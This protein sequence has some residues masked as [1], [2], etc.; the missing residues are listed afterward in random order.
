MRTARCGNSNHRMTYQ[1]T[2]PITALSGY[3]IYIN[4]EIP[5]GSLIVD[6]YI[7]GLVINISNESLYINNKYINYIK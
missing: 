1:V 6:G 5:Q 2:G 3:C 7:L 4:I